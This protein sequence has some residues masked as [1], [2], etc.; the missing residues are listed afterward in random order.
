MRGER[1]ALLLGHSSFY[2]PS[3]GGLLHSYR[4]PR[5]HLTG[6]GFR[7]LAAKGRRNRGIQLCHSITMD[8][9][10]FRLPRAFKE[11]RNHWYFLTPSIPRP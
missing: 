5:F 3:E 6:R 2:T 10:C 7:L 4:L 9:Y 1:A 11:G 8:D